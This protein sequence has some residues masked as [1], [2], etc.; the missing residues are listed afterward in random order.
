MLTNS[1]CIFI[2]FKQKNGR[3]KEN[4]MAKVFI[5][6]VMS[7]SFKFKLSP[8]VNIGNN[9]PDTSV[10]V[11]RIGSL[12]E[13]V[14]CGNHTHLLKEYLNTEIK[15][16]NTKNLTINKIIIYFLIQSTMTYKELNC[17]V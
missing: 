4:V 2:R 10:S 17:T 3:I 12:I 8:A 6:T 11:Y 7:T 14:T 15:N 16:V 13:N 9:I 5:F 1:R